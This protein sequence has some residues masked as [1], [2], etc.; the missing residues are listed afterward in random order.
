MADNILA[1]RLVMPSLGDME[2]IGQD[3]GTVDLLPIFYGHDSM[4]PHIQVVR[5]SRDE[6]GKLVV[7]SVEGRYKLELKENGKLSL[8]RGD[9][10]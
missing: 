4:G 5:G 2:L 8:R 7:R 3:G 1:L 10:S 6:K 9:A